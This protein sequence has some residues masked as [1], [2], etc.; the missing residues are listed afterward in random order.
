MDLHDES[1]SYV[2]MYHHILHSKFLNIV[3]G[4]DDTRLG[5]FRAQYELGFI[6]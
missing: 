6:A 5:R 1:G 4:F 3:A 2:V